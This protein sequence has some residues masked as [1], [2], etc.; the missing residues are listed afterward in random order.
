MKVTNTENNTGG[1]TVT[2]I[3]VKVIHNERTGY[4]EAFRT[5]K[6]GYIP[7]GYTLVKN[8]RSFTIGVEEPKVEESKKKS[9]WKRLFG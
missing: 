5:T 3:Y 1:N 4:D 9:F 7:K 2:T 6:P 8:L